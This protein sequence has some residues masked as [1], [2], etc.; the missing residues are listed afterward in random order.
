[1]ISY[2]D[3][4]KQGGGIHS[5]V[6]ATRKISKDKL[7]ES[8]IKKLNKLLANGTTT[9]EIKSGYGLDYETEKKMLEIIN[10]L[11]EEHL[12]DIIPTFLGAHTIPKDVDREKYIDWIV[13]KAIP[14]FKNLARYCDIFCEDGAFSLDETEKIFKSAI[15]NG[16]RLKI[17]SG[18]F[19]DLGASGLSAN[20]KA[21]SA[22]HLENIS[23]EQIRQMRENGT[24]AVLLPGVPFYLQSEK[25]ANARLMIKENLPVAIATDFNPGSCPS[26]SMQMMISLA[27]LKMNMTI[28]EAIIASTINS[29]VAIEKENE[30]GSL[31]S[32]K[33]ADFIILD[34]ENYKQIP[35]FY[36]T[37][38][39][40][41]VVKNGNVL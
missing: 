3:I 22:D 31:E 16:Y 15:E 1:G 30:V 34:V 13:E 4:L 19:N 20:L 7:K 40:K 26:Y 9:V 5:T 11:N 35:Y 18:Q 27:C 25:Y 29:A 38:L 33:Q 36:G 23:L 21:V 24:I 32:G 37:N 17:H 14:D 28:E 41:T 2:L 39:I 10:E 12:M 8:S 6:E